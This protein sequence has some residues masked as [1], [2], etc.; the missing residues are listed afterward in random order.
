MEAKTTV[1]KLL[2]TLG[3]IVTN[4]KMDPYISEKTI[5]RMTDIIER[6]ISKEEETQI[7]CVVCW[8]NKKTHVFIPCGHHA[9]CK[10]CVDI[11]KTFETI[12]CPIC[13]QTG[14]YYKIFSSGLKNT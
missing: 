14:E 11:L 7:S 5:L 10:E 4:E 3:K 6:K 12:R 13:R 8:K 9:F 2:A 1:D